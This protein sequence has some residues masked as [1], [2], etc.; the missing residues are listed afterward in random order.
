MTGSRA[1]RTM[2]LA[3]TRAIVSARPSCTTGQRARHSSRS[4]PSTCTTQGGWWLHQTTILFCAAIQRMAGPRARLVEDHV[5]A[6]ASRAARQAGA[7]HS[8]FATEMRGATA[9]RGSGA[10]L[11]RCWICNA[12]MY[13]QVTMRLSWM[14]TSSPSA[15]HEMW[16]LSFC[17][18]TPNAALCAKGPH[19]MHTGSSC[20]PFPNL[21]HRCWLSRRMRWNGRSAMRLRREKR[22]RMCGGARLHAGPRVICVYRAL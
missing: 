4:G 19:E 14:H 12:P 16:R 18:P 6:V 11:A 2:P 1:R 5:E 21:L 3:G 22:W 20:R 9:T 8:T 7:I 17:S 13:G 15:F 10:T